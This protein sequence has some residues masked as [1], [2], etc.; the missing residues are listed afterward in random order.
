MEVQAAINKANE[1]LTPAST[2]ML[3]LDELYKVSCQL[4]HL[5]ASMDCSLSHAAFYTEDAVYTTDMALQERQRQAE[6]RR[7][8][9]PVVVA[10]RGDR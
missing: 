1:L 6:K 8:T 4:H 7:Y 9:K 5:L 2:G 10:V 3:P